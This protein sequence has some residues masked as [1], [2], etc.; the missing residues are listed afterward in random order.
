MVTTLEKPKTAFTECYFCKFT[1]IRAFCIACG[2]AV[3]IDCYD[4]KFYKDRCPWCQE[5]EYR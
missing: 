1:A 3:C 4:D 5:A 2:L